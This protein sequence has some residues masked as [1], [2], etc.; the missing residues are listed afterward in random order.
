MFGYACTGRGRSGSCAET[1]GKC[2]P[3]GGKNTER[4]R[5]SAPALGW[6]AERTN[7]ATPSEPAAP[8]PASGKTPASSR[9]S[10][11]ETQETEDISLPL[12]NYTDQKRLTLYRHFYLLLLFHFYC[13]L[14]LSFK[15]KYFTIIIYYYFIVDTYIHIICITI[16]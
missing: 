14:T 16:I 7:H 13:Y 2:R 8:A 11:S 12:I 6:R 1:P 5:D 15:N 3:I 10:S 4:R 9:D